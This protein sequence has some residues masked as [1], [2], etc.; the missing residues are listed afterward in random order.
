M[1]GQQI[2]LPGLS[3]PLSA[4]YQ[5]IG[6]DYQKAAESSK[7]FADTVSK[8]ARAAQG[9]FVKASE[10]MGEGAKEAGEKAAAGGQKFSVMGQAIAVAAGNA[11]FAIAGKFVG[12][13]QS[14]VGAVTG[15]VK[16]GMQL[17]G[18]FGEMR[19]SA[20]A[21]GN[22]MGLANDEVERGIDALNEA[23]IRYDVA[24]QTA[25]Q[26][27]KNQ[28]DLARAGE[29]A[30][31]AQGAAVLLQEDSSATMQKLVGAIASGS[32][33]TL[34]RIGITKTFAEME[35]AGAV[36]L[37]KTTE[38]MT[39]QEIMTA[40]LNGVL[41]ESAALQGVYAAASESP[42]KKLRS[43][44]GR[45]IPELQ[46]ALTE[47]LMPA[48]FTVID[49]AS[50]F[51]ESLTGLLKEGGALYPVLVNIGAAASIAAD[52]F[53]S[54]VRPVQ[55]LME[56]LTNK[57][58]VDDFREGFVRGI[59]RMSEEGTSKAAILVRNIT[60]KLSTMAS[61]ALTWGINI[62][63]QFATGIIQGAAKALTG[64]MNVI[65]GMLSNWL[66]PG[67]PP[68]VAKDI[69]QWGAGTMNEYLRGFGE[70]SFDMLDKLQAP[71]EQTL[72]SLVDAGQIGAGASKEM[73]KGLT[74]EMTGAISKF[75]QTGKVS[76]ELF[77]RLKVAGGQYGEDLSEL[78]RR[79]FALAKATMDVERAEESLAN[80]RTKQTDAQEKLG[81][82]VDEYN[83][84]L[85]EGASPQVLAAKRA[86]FETARDRLK[87]ADKEVKEADARKKAAGEAVSPLE[88]QAAVQK[89]LLDHML[90]FNK[91]QT[92]AAKGVKDIAK[93]AAAGAKGAAGSI[94]DALSGAGMGGGLGDGIGD[95]LS[96]GIGEAVEGV[97]EQLREK[98][99]DLFAPVREAWEELRDGP[100]LELRDAW[101]KFKGPALEALGRVG[102]FIKD[103]L[104]PILAG[105]AA[106][107]AAVVIPIFTGWAAVAVPAAAATVTALA[108]VILTIAAIGLAAG[109]LVKAWK[110]DWGGIRTK[111]TEVWDK[112]LKPGF[113]SIKEWLEEKVPLAIE[114]LKQFWEE[115][116]KPAMETVQ[117]FIVEDLIP[118]FS[119]LVT[120]IGEK[121]A[122]A[123]DTAKSLFEQ[124]KDVLRLL[125]DFI[126][127]KILP[128]LEDLSEY[129]QDAFAKG[130][131]TALDI[132]GKISKAFNNIKDAISGVIEFVGSLISMMGDL[133]NAIPDWL[134]TNSPPKM[135]VAFDDIGDAMN[136]VSM[137]AIPIM[138]AQLQG[139]GE[140]GQNITNNDMSLT[141]Q[142]EEREPSIIQNL[143]VARALFMP[144]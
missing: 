93:S 43:L 67:S 88:K 71:L 48:W 27:A 131:E 129:L 120:W 103:N 134:E 62:S 22:F 24:A 32:S 61:N 106:I 140:T 17:A 128:I 125:W 37:G 21:V 121:I 41:A 130:M 110:D 126:K 94:A 135:A 18:R 45:V 13:V 51:A 42:T 52:L 3:V 137:N 9:K 64:A 14:A 36:A 100:L 102:A 68:K 99:G 104:V 11:A 113:E 75:Q 25:A 8:Q 114:K 66:S 141:I 117:T 105:V 92:K 40:R 108:P 76:S 79:Q 124:F 46:A 87:V 90:K 57:K 82:V 60:D 144:E 33:M 39:K 89:R 16:S 101:D 83:K 77:D 136:N 115:T 81:G 12:A 118:A 74:V 44:T 111:F 86:E 5:Q 123:V 70:A 72:S 19:N 54:A 7:K 96:G 35:A 29:L 112:K 95:A 34:K 30:N 119:D 49:T 107:I 6:K 10:G 20:L 139:M 98:L 1:A 23:G 28:L 91:A 4:D 38:Q 15:F 132:I 84:L 59:D 73:M 31:A 133:G 127:T 2:T 143:Q 142:T 53:S 116:L 122:G 65:G 63:V 109:L 138:R 26:F 69:D 97:K 80:A 58:P 55:A 50:D 85:E 78:A 56:E 47:S